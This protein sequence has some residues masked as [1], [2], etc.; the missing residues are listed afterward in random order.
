V[1]KPT[2]HVQCQLARGTTDTTTWLPQKYAVVGDF[3]KLRDDDG[4]WQDGWEVM[5]TGTVL[6]TD[7]VM[8]RERDHLHQR[9]ASDI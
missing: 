5:V 8:E 2:F 9:E 3:V 7:V 4:V 1:S 6:P